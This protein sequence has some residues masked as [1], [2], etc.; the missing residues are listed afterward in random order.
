[1]GVVKKSEEWIRDNCSVDSLMVS[2]LNRKSFAA[3]RLLV[4]EVYLLS[5]IIELNL[6]LPR[7]LSNEE[8]G[9]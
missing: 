2:K 8:L 7:K 1:M 3:H 4:N 9:N 5:H 6:V